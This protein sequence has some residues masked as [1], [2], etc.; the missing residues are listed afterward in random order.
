MFLKYGVDT[1][2]LNLSGDN[3]TP[4]SP[5]DTTWMSDAEVAAAMD[6][7]RCGASAAPRM[8]A[9]RRRSSRRCATAST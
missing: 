5:A 8:R 9:R 6:E 3:F 7:V 4:D 2:K 1:I